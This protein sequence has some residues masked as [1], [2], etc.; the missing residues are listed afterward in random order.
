[1]TNQLIGKQRG[2]ITSVGKYE[3]QAEIGRGGM[4]AVYQAY[5]PVLDRRVAIKVLAPHLVWEPAFVE[6]FM[7]EARAAARLKHTSI[8]TI[9]DVGQQSTDDSGG[10]L[11]YIV[12]EYL[13]GQT[14]AAHVRQHGPLP[15]A[16]VVAILRPLAD[17]LDYAHQCGLIHRD[18]KPGNIMISPSG[19]ATLTDFGIAR[20]VQEAR[21][22]A[23]GAI[24]GTPEY[25]SPEQAWGE[26]V[27]SHTDLY[28]LAVVAYEMLCGRV[29]FS[30]TTPH[31]VLYKQIHEPPPPIR[32]TRPDL[33]AGLEMVLA[34]ALAKEPGKRYPTVTAFVDALEIALA[35]A[36]PAEAPTVIRTD[37]VRVEQRHPSAAREHPERAS[38]GPSIPL[39][40][41]E[42][43]QGKRPRR[44]L[45]R[46]IW[47]LGGLAVLLL[48]SGG[49]ALWLGDGAG[50][51]PTPTV[52]V[53]LAPTSTAS[54]QATSQ[55]KVSPIATRASVL[56]PVECPDPLGCVRIGKDEP[57]QIAYLLVLSGPDKSL[58]IDAKRAVEMAVEDAGA[59]SG[60]RILG[61]RIELAG[62][63]SQCSEAGGERAAL[64]LAG[65]P[66]L[67]AIVGPSC[68]SA[69]RAAI[70]VI[71][72]A[73]MPL[74]SPSNTTPELTAPDRPPSYHCYLR[75][76]QSDVVQ[77]L[78]AAQFVRSLGIKK[79][80][81]IHD[82]S[83]YSER[84]QQTFAVEFRKLGGVITAQEPIGPDGSDAAPVLARVAASGPEIIYYPL[85]I[86]AAGQVTRQ[87]RG[88]PDLK[89]V[90]LM[91]ADG[92][93]APALLEG[94][95]EAAIGM[96]LSSPDFTAL[97]PEYEHFRQ[98]YSEKYGE[99]PI[100]PFHAHAYDAAMMIFD[101]IKRVAMPRDDGS[102]YIGRQALQDTLFATRNFKGLTG[103]LTC[104]SHGDC[105]EARIAI[106]EVTKADPA[107]WSPGDGPDSNPR[108]IWP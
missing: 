78:A 27:D 59:S 65:D 81:T 107:S 21:L 106:F 34:Q 48:V 49:V 14:L 90:K 73:N 80:A 20:A 4:G 2:Q 18:I 69:A 103:N 61:H 79:A 75:T 38:A 23:T 19:Q 54:P 95:G 60:G 29:P 77:G 58:G 37:D 52:G 88:N 86:E 35:V 55:P 92:M 45:P 11:Y 5:D 83:L 56:P 7:R 89:G 41:K 96:F 104:D 68:S 98:R 25:M 105:A 74:I 1:M 39:P 63:D 57:I 66:K 30:G 100:G 53:G 47:V 22:T 62:Q 9:Y 87:A 108:R 44:P 15:P 16:E 67:V 33:P 50:A 51:S 40:A 10:V 70:P 64:Q 93:F 31:A 99:P 82:G 12:M 94:A 3:I 42:R 6:R 28:S 46:W 84:L 76:T 26:E 91:G 102:L 36:L 85:F 13:D 101:A 71:C 17:A 43:V 24:M 8:V 72:R 32:Q 97:G